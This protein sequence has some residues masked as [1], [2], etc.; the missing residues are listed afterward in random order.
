MQPTVSKKLKNYVYA[1]CER[2]GDGRKTIFYIG[3]GTGSRC[4]QHLKTKDD[5]FEKIDKLRKSK[6]LTID[7]LRHGLDAEAAK[8]VEATCID[9]LPWSNLENKIKGLSIF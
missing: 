3:R 8:V 4:L 7:I 6:N 9:L 1:L 5:K 2:H